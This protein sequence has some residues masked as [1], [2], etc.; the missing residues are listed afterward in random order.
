MLKDVCLRAEA[1][2]VASLI[3]IYSM[4]AKTSIIMPRQ[5]SQ[6]RL[7][8]DPD[9]RGHGRRQASSTV[10]AK[11]KERLQNHRVI[12][13]M[14]VSCD[15]ILDRRG[16]ATGSNPQTPTV[17]RT[18]VAKKSAGPPRSTGQARA[19]TRT[20]RRNSLRCSVFTHKNSYPGS[21]QSGVGVVDV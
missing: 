21:P 14:S 10:P 2:T 3:N 5:N 9:V 4:S 8:P 7:K 16:A 17:W 1:P 6:S 12:R 13:T 11:R 20:E 15:C 18:V 19:R